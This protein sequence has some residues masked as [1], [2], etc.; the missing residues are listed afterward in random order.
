MPRA[1]Q[2]RL[3][4]ARAALIAVTTAQ[5]AIE[6]AVRVLDE[7]GAQD[8]A[9]RAHL[10]TEPLEALNRDTA[11]LVDQVKAYIPSRATDEDRVPGDERHTARKRVAAQRS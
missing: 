3:Q 6:D 8:L 10:L 4:K 7:L 1:A 5:V 2:A 11:R 9:G